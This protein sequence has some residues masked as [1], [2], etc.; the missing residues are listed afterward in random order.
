[1]PKLVDCVT[2]LDED[3]LLELRLN[4]LNSYVDRFIIVEAKQTHQGNKK[5]LNFNINN[6]K[7]FKKKIEYYIKDDLNYDEYKLEKK[8]FNDGSTEDWARENSQRNYLQ[9][10]IK[11]YHSD[12][13]I[14][15]SDVDE[16]PRLEHFKMEGTFKRFFLFEQDLFYYKF[17]LKSNLK[18]IGTRLC[19][20]KYLVS[21]Q[22]LRDLYPKRKLFYNLRNFIKIIKNGGWHFSY[23]KSM[24]GISKKLNQFAH[25]EYNQSKFKSYLNIKK[26]IEKQVDLF[27]R[28]TTFSKV[29]LNNSFPNYL[30]DNQI[31]LK[32]W[33]L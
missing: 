13:L 11:K 4:T 33:I 27:E 25:R 9:K 10:A 1:M 12:D 21:P 20:K 17:N 22:Q 18:T 14:M 26:A 16:I 3:L 7:K 23:L 15:I 31:R 6:F 28:D 32:K 30:V 29:D 2:Y 19:K 8:F 5:K 24:R